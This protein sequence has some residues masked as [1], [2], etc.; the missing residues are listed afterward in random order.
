MNSSILTDRPVNP[1]NQ[2]LLDLWLISRLWMLRS[3]GIQAV[4]R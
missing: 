2:V 1:M 4:E 3:P